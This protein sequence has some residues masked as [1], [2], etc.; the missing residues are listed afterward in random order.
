MHACAA[1]LRIRW[2][3]SM[4]LPLVVLIGL[5]PG[6]AVRVA[7]LMPDPV[8]LGAGVVGLAGLTFFVRLAAHR[9]EARAQQH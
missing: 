4:A 3:L 2:F 6:A 8:V 7:G 1:C 5:R 9:R